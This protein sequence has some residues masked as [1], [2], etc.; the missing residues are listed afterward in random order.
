MRTSTFLVT[1]ANRGLG[2]ETA[3]Q[4]AERGH[5]VLLGIRDATKGAETETAMRDAGLDAHFVSLD[6]G[7]AASI[8]RAAGD[9][10]KRF[11]ALDGLINN[12]AIHYDTWQRVGAP[13]FAIAEEA[14]SVNTLGPWRASVALLPLLRQSPAGRIVNVSS[15]SGQLSSMNGETP[16]YC[17]SKIA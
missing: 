5:R 15:M 14:F 13:D 4:L 16:A 17:L 10:G 2:R 3:K 7:D 11:G 9:I 6:T 8:E 1:G 12:A